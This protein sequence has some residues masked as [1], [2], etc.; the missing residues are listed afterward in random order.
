MKNWNFLWIF[1]LMVFVACSGMTPTSNSPCD[2]V[3]VED[4]LIC[5][6]IPNPQDVDLL[7][8]IGNLTAIKEYVYKAGQA[9]HVIQA[10]EAGLRA[11]PD[12]TYSYLYELL[13]D[14]V[15]PAIFLIVTDYADRFGSLEVPLLPYDRELLLRHLERQRQVILMLRPDLARGIGNGRKEVA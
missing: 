11:S 5:E 10:I 12:L 9:L 14:S 8:R 1:L 2:G 7:L 13:R 3:P 4:S 15:D 6:H